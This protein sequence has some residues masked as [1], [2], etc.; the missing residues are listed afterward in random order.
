M[1]E[2]TRDLQPIDEPSTS[3]DAAGGDEIEILSIEPGDAGEPDGRPAPE[4]AGAPPA[5]PGGGELELRRELEDLR[6][7]SLRAMADF[8]NFRKRAEREREELRRHALTGALGE[9]LPVVDNLERAVSAQGSLEDLRLGVEMTLRQLQEILRRM[10]LREVAAVGQ[11]FDPHVHE[12][13]MREERPGLTEPTVTA[14]LLRGYLLHD[15]VLRPAMV[16]VAVPPESEDRAAASE[17]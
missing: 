1:D 9:L 8:D 17:S 4:G 14:E 6:D 7:R 11:R 16:T 12:A 2:R 5:E 15:R 10:G 3:H 13:V